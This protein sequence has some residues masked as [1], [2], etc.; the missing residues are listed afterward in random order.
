MTKKIRNSFSVSDQSPDRRRL[1]VG[2]G[3]P[4]SKYSG[5]RHNVGWRVVDMLAKRWMLGPESK[6][7]NS[8][9]VAGMVSKPGNDGS[10]RVTLLKPTTFMNRSGRAVREALDFYK[11][12]REDMLVILDDMNLPLGKLR[13]RMEGSAGGH[14]GLSD[15]LRVMGGLDVPRLRIGIGLPSPGWDVIDF[16]LA[17]FTK[18]ELVEI[19]VAVVEAA[20]A[21]EDWLFHGMKNVMDRYNGR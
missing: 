3:N 5:T 13:A 14:N 2:L 20:D 18:D 21:V 7:F 9:A 17:A 16:V 19:D 12:E 6:D 10:P 8:L 4:G 1:I 15:V 11:I